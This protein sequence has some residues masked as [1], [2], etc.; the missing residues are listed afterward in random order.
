MNAYNMII[1]EKSLVTS[2][3][4]NGLDICSDYDHVVPVFNNDV[5]KINNAIDPVRIYDQSF[6]D[7]NYDTLVIGN[8]EFVLSVNTDKFLDDQD[9]DFLGIDKAK[10]AILST[11]ATNSVNGLKDLKPLFKDVGGQKDVITKIEEEIRKAKIEY[12]KHLAK[13]RGK[14]EVKE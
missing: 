2:F 6:L 12:K 13:K 11:E 9:V 3:L 8:H 5:L 4:N 7:K 1:P 10:N 14:Q